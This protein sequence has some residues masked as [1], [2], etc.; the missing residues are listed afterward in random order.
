VFRELEDQKVEFLKPNKSQVKLKTQKTVIDSD[1][2]RSL[3]H[4]TAWFSLVC[5]FYFTNRTKPNQT[6]T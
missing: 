5:G 3:F 4:S 1:V 2:F 6:A